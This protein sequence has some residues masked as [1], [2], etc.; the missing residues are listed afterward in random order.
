MLGMAL[1]FDLAAVEGAAAAPPANLTTTSDSTYNLYVGNLHSHT[2]YSDGEGTPAQAYEYA[3]DSAG[4][5]FLAVTDHHHFLDTQEYSDILYQA[6]RFTEDG[7][8]VGIGGQE[9]TGNDMNHST[10]WDAPRIL[11]A[12][13][14]DYDSLYREVYELDCTAAFCH[15]LPYNFGYFAYSAVGDVC[16]NAVEV[17]SEQEEDRYIDILNNGWHVGTDGSQDN[18][19]ANWGNGYTWTVA[20][21]CSLTKAH[22]LDATRNH[23]T[24]STLDRN[25]EMIF[26]A[27]G[28]YMGDEFAHTDDIA[29]SIS[30]HDPDPYDAFRRLELYQN[31]LKIAW[32]VIDTTSYT[33]SPAVTPT[34]GENHYF[35]KV[36]QDLQQR[37]WSA[38]IWI[39]CSTALPATPRPETPYDG[40]TVTTLSPTFTWHTSENA[41]TYVLRCSSSDTFPLD[42]STLTIP[43]I[44]DTFYTM[45]DVLEDDVWY[46]WQVRAANEQGS[47]TYSGAY[48]FITDEDASYVPAAD[49]L[50][51]A[52]EGFETCPNPFREKALIEFTL[53]RSH[54]VE[55]AVYDVGGQLVR[56][57]S[58][59]VHGAGCHCL[60]WDGTDFQGHRLAPGIY[61]CRLNAGGQ[62]AVRK[63]VLLE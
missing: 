27:E 31:G 16:I 30:V 19:T 13:L 12:P 22:I 26:R 57:L 55:V 11:T 63:A 21:A 32:T 2:S 14:N 49:G 43:G 62:Q 5:D 7:V 3:R 46:Y 29:F 24:Y 8:F 39:D 61:L 17:R 48:S 38:P 37:A 41:E 47:S 50:T 54:H 53:S 25:L 52:F 34:N 40:Q 4:V 33:W 51:P 59:T 23:R 6:D 35:V 58:D 10:V 56:T 9:W 18:H 42:E 36:Y 28:H 60:Q 15:P 20:L 44:N 1:V 45:Q